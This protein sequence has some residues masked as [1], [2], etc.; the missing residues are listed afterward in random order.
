MLMEEVGERR[1]KVIMDGKKSYK[2]RGLSDLGDGVC[3]EGDEGKERI[4]G[5]E[6]E[7]KIRQRKRLGLVRQIKVV[8]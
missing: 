6:R 5:K 8:H 1:E 7:E 4:G 3:R 2:R